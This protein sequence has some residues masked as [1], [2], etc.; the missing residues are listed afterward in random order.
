MTKDSLW[1]VLP[2][3]LA[4]GTHVFPMSEP[5]FILCVFAYFGGVSVCALRYGYYRGC[6]RCNAEGFNAAQKAAQT[7]WWWKL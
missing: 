2:L 7:E 3:L 6:I 1:T 4:L 5:V